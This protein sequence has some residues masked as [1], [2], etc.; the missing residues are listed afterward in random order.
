VTRYV[1][2]IR[3]MNVGGKNLVKMDRLREMF[4]ECGYSDV[5]TY[6]QSGNVVFTAKH[7][8]AR[9]VAAIERALTIEMGKPV[10]AQIRS[11]AQIAKIVAANPYARRKGLNPALL[12][13]SFLS[14][15]LGAAQ[16]K[17]LRGVKSGDDTFVAR[18]N[19]LYIYCPDGYGRSKLAIAIDRVLTKTTTS[20]NWNTVTKLCEMSMLPN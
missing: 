15:P 5:R 3:A 11:A 9:C 7:A 17:A 6:I 16:I 1:A 18:G 8:P 4:E 19:E 14:E 13:V 12:A 2:I 20:R 10:A